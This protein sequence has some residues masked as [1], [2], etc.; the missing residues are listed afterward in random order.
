MYRTYLVSI[1][2]ASH[3][4]AENVSSH[5]IRVT[6]EMRCPLNLKIFS[7]FKNFNLKILLRRQMQDKNSAVYSVLLF[8]AISTFLTIA[9]S[10]E[11][12][13]YFSAYVYLNPEL[14]L[15][16]KNRL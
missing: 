6:S 15:S 14:V 11:T 10:Q 3:P 7:W 5:L 13:I 8:C 12:K 1:S 2:S 16:L 4:F 9:G